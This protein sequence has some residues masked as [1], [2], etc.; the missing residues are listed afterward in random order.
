MGDHPRKSLADFLTSW[1][2]PRNSLSPWRWFSVDWRNADGNQ[3]RALYIDNCMSISP[4]GADPGQ[5]SHLPQC[6]PP[7]S[8][9]GWHHTQIGLHFVEYPLYKYYIG[10][11]G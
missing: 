5:T 10:F 6:T 3:V 2:R 11:S 4:L 1:K 9:T 7:L 8:E